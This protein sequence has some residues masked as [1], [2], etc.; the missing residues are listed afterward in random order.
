MYLSY[1]SIFVLFND[2]NK[3]TRA[4]ILKYNSISLSLKNRL[5]AKNG[6]LTQHYNLYLKKS[7]NNNTK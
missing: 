3:S 5:Q 2:L 1:L 7:A 4:Y 6:Q